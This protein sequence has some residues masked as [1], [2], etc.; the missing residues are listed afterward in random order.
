MRRLAGWH[1]NEKAVVGEVGHAM[2][3]GQAH[4]VRRLD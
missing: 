2:D 4:I 3:H 1:R